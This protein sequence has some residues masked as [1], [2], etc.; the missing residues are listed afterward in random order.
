MLTGNLTACAGSCGPGSLHFINGLFESHR[1]RAPVVLIASQVTND[2]VGFDFPQEVDF[3]PIY[4]HCSVFCEEIRSP[5]HIDATHLGRRHPIT[6]GA[7][8]DVKATVEALLPRITPR[9][10]RR[11]LDECLDRY[12]RAVAHANRRAKVGRSGAIHPQ[13]PAALI[14][15]YAA[16]DAIFAADAGSPTVWL[17]RHVQANGRRRTIIS[18]T[19]GTMANAMPQALGAK[20]ALPQR[21]VI[22]LSAGRPRPSQSCPRPGEHHPVFDRA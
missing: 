16:E 8:G 20:K 22:S 2:E 13:Y 1:N 10:D 19:H 15:K 3:K 18:L 12:A 11:F 9:T 21:Q 14:S 4:Q 7:V 17:L 5:A 6:F